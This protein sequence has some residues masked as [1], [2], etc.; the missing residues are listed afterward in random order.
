MRFYPENTRLSDFLCNLVNNG[1]Q[2]TVLTNKPVYPYNYRYNFKSKFYSNYK[3]V[4]VIRVP[5]IFFGDN[6][7]SKI[8][9]FVS[10]IINGSI[11]G[12]FLLIGKNFDILLTFAPSPPTV[13]IPSIIISKFKNKPTSS[14]LFIKTTFTNTCITYI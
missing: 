12:S 8:F 1:H 6:F 14:F 7:I 3:G 9:Y 4:N 13:C 10:F 5:I 11:F 2:V